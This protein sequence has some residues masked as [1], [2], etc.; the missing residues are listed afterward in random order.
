[1]KFFLI[2]FT[3][4]FL[5]NCGTKYPF[6]VEES[7]RKLEIA[8]GTI[9]SK[10]KDKVEKFLL[11]STGD[12]FKIEHPQKRKKILKIDN[13]KYCF[14]LQNVTETILKTQAIN[15]IGDTL[16]FVEYY[17]PKLGI[18]FI[19]KW[20]PRFKTKNSIY[21]RQLYDSLQA[22]TFGIKN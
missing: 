20:H 5:S 16:N 7:N 8:W 4:F 19:A 17:N 10:Q 21:F 3:L 12:I 6:C 18:Y 13:D 11:I 22:L 15:E 2:F 9:F 1:M 14:V